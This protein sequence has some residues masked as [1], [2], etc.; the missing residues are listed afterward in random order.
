MKIIQRGIIPTEEREVGKEI[1]CST[2][3]S[4]LEYFTGDLKIY[5]NEAGSILYFQCPVCNHSVVVET[6]YREP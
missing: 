1:T 2:C 3:S 5:Q 4:I 6:T